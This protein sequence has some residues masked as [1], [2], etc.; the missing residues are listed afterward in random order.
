MI[1]SIWG[2][3][4]MTNKDSENKMPDD[5]NKCVAF[6]GHICPGL[7]YGYRVAKEAMKLMNLS[8]SV[9]EEVVAI[10]ENDSCAV[11]ALQVLLGTVV[12]KGNLIINN[13]GKNAFTVLSRTQRQAYRFYRNTRYDYKGKDKREFDRLE[14][15]VAAGN[16]SEDDR[17]NLKRL[18]VNDLLTR[19]FEEIFTT[20]EMPFDEPLYAPLAPSEPCAICGEMTMA[21]KMMKLKDGRQACLPCSKKA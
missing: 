7:I 10:C 14:A 15:V 17:R 3:V 1:G 9:D 21:S 6:H 16:A 19:P 4:L 18:K 13:F 11:D 5:L 8:R 20:T 12:G 2:E